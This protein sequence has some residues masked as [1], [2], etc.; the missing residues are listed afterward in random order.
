MQ[1]PDKKLIF[2][3]TFALLLGAVGC[4]FWLIQTAHFDPPG[5][6][7]AG[8]IL[9]FAAPWSIVVIILVRRFRAQEPDFQRRIRFSYAAGLLWAAL[10][11]TLTG[12][13]Y[14]KWSPTTYAI[15]HNMP[16]LAGMLV[17]AGIAVNKRDMNGQTPLGLAINAGDVHLVASLLR[18]G[19]DVNLEIIARQPRTSVRYTPLRLAILKR[20]DVIIEILRQAGAKE[21]LPPGGKP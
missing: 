2:Y 17:Q 20:D 8:L 16:A 13:A 18:H 4:F 5:N 1:L 14:A 3:S 21:T 15:R 12:M 10:L 9:A 6:F 7:W 19:A 11:M